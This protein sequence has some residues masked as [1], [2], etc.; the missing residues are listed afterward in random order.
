MR[1]L[2]LRRLAAAVATSVALLGTG[3]AAAAPASALS[4]VTYTVEAP[5]TSW[6]G[7]W[8]TLG[9][10]CSTECPNG[11]LDAQVAISGGPTIDLPAEPDYTVDWQVQGITSGPPEGT[12]VVTHT[13]TVTFTDETGSARTLT[14]QMQVNR[15]HP[16]YVENLVGNDGMDA[17]VT[18][19]P[20]LIDGGSPVT[21]YLV[22]VDEDPWIELGAAARS[23][24]LAG[25]TYGPHEVRV[26]A[27]NAVG[28]GW[29]D[30]VTVLRGVLPSA[31]VVNV[32]GTAHPTVAWTASVAG[33]TSVTGYVVY[34]GGVAVRT[35]GAAARSVTLDDLD[36]GSQDLQVAATCAWGAGTFSTAVEW[37]QA[38]VPSALSTPTVV[39]GNGKAH[40]VVGGTQRRRRD[41]C[42]VVQGAR[43]RRRDLDAARH[44]D[45]QRP[46]RRRDRPPQ[47][48]PGPRPGR[49][50]QRARDLRMDERR[51]V[52]R[53]ERPQA[54]VVHAVRV[55][56][57]L[58]A[59]GDAEGHRAR[60]AGHHEQVRDGPEGA[61]L[62][63]ALRLRQGR[64]LRPS[65]SAARAPG[66]SPGPSAPRPRC[67][68]AT[69]SRP[70]STPR[71]R[72]ARSSR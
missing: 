33:G 9:I 44:R 12:G 25:L 61:G 11:I 17:T 2:A 45:D 67:R 72:A 14:K 62:D 1:A 38:T 59:D 71:R 27:K 23:F 3:L 24:S 41:A 34:S 69:S 19:E 57:G 32:T 49:G 53:A 42:H 35:L 37:V 64:A 5:A 68:R 70:R 20:P 18:W 58:H 8:I 28:W 13:L 47:R 63:Q 15:D 54:V 21:N 7:Q 56:V 31:P 50:G 60:R 30:P 29:G 10:H 43:D 48:V 22:R 66:R 46:Q 36:P 52:G 65:R 6:V 51:V 40:R 26:I 55:R 4:P 39:P 16:Q